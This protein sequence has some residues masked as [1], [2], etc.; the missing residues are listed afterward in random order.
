MRVLPNPN[1]KLEDLLT[2]AKQAR[3]P[4]DREAW[5][6]ISFFLGNQYVEWHATRD[7]P[8]GFLR[9]L[10]PEKGAEDSPRMVFNKIMQFVRTAQ[11]DAIKDRPTP[12]VQPATADYMDISDSRVAKAW[13]DNQCDPTNLDYDT[14]LGRAAHM[15]LLAGNGYLKHCW[16]G[17]TDKP[18]LHAPSFFEVFLDPYAKLFDDCR[19]IIQ[20]TFMDVEQVYE[21]YGVEVKPTSS[22]EADIAKSALLRSIGAAPALTGVVVNEIWHKPSRRYKKGL[23]AVWA[24]RDQLYAPDDLPYPH[25]IEDRTLPYTQLGV[26]ER[27]DSPYH[28]SPVQFLRPPQMELNIYHNQMLQNRK[29]FAN[30]KVYLPAGVELEEPWDQSPHQVLKNIGTDPMAE[31]KIIQP[32]VFPNNQD[33]DVL[34]QGMMHV[35]GQREVSNAQVPGRVEAAK[36]IELLKEADAGALTVLNKTINTSV[37]RGAYHFLQLARHF[38]KSSD[39]VPTYSKEGLPEV[40]HFMAGKMKPGFRVRTSATTGLARSR[41]NRVETVM[42]MV[43]LGI[44]DKDR[45]HETIGELLETPL[46]TTRANADD[47]MRARNENLL[48]AEGTAIEPQAWHNHAVHRVEHDKYRNSPDYDL[49]SPEG[50][51]VFEHHCQRHDVLEDE[52]IAKQARKQMIAQGGQPSQPQPATAVGQLDQEGPTA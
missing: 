5:L 24:G 13:V 52:Q 9:E 28:L 26:I 12:D 1:R 19:Y 29:N 4:Y 2:A 14:R 27:P 44:L 38:Q 31:P 51:K 34:E 46:T 49:L 23:Y 6:N 41:T 48:L 15:A 7:D 45:D 21:M 18:T 10:E 25:L 42:R 3:L 50:K 40:K 20:S 22:S 33:L 39:L 43:E 47:R 36:A 11:A 37:A 16:N 17:Q 35:V 30:G 8:V 32:T